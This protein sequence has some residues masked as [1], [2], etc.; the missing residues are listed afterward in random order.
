MTILTM[1]ALKRLGASGAAE[2]QRGRPPCA[3]QPHV[4]PQGVGHRARCRSAVRLNVFGL[5]CASLGGDIGHVVRL[6]KTRA[7]LRTIDLDVGTVAILRRHRE[8]QEVPA[9]SLGRGIAKYLSERLGHDSVQTTLELYGHV[10]S[11]R[12]SDAAHRIG[13]MLD[14]VP[15]RI[16]DPAVAPRPE[17]D[18]DGDRREAK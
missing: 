16:R 9:T 7:G 10:T 12:R 14:E 5:I 1:L 3:I 6:P 17:K 2:Q 8:A 11:K 4:H 15:G 13:A 18:A